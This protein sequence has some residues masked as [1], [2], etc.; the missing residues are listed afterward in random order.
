M[1]GAPRWRNLTDHAIVILA[2]DKRVVLPPDGLVARVEISHFE[3]IS[4]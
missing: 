4:S 1:S 2:D 3:M